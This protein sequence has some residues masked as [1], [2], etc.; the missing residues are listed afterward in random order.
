MAKERKQA[1]KQAKHKIK[2]VQLPHARGLPVPGYQSH[3][4]AGFDLIAAVDANSPIVI[5]A[6]CRALVPTGLIFQLPDGTE[7]QVRPRSGLAL[8]H[9][10]TVLNSPGTIDSD[11]RGEVQVILV[12]LG[13]QPF[14]ITRGE[15]IAQFVLAPVTR[16]KFKLKSSAAKTPRGTRG[17]GSTGTGVHTIA[18]LEPVARKKSAMAVKTPPAPKRIAIVGSAKKNR[19]SQQLK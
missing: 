13:D 3:G 18:V 4:A 12:N 9:G 7:G 16:A 1:R 17:F 8:K 19:P 10:I 11:Y 14:R 2:L 6:G 15:R 5:K